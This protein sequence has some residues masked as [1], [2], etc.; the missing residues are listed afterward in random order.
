METSKTKH[1]VEK[2]IWG[3]GL[4]IGCNCDKITPSAIGVDRAILPEV[5]LIGYAEDLD[6]FTDECLDFVYSSHT[7]EDL[8]DTEGVL[9]EWVRVIKP[10]GHLMLYLPHKDFYPNIGHPLANK[11]H[12]HDFVPDDIV[13]ILAKI[14]QTQVIENQTFGCGEYDYDNRAN[15]EYSFLIVAEK[16]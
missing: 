11:A 8:E 4:D 15:I 5:N 13:K 9:R 14:G 3:N 2:Y 16:I 6:W 7:L 10:R 12:K 1:R